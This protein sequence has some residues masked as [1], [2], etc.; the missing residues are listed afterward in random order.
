ML[1]VTLNFH[2]DA[3]AAK[4][5][6][7]LSPVTDDKHFIDQLNACPSASLKSL[8]FTEF[9][10]I[11]SVKVNQYAGH[12]PIDSDEYHTLFKVLNRLLYQ[13]QSVDILY[14]CKSQ[15]F[16]IEF[17]LLKPK[18]TRK[19]KVDLTIFTGMNETHVQETQ[20]EP[21]RPQLDSTSLIFGCTLGLMLA[22]I[23]ALN[24]WALLVSSLFAGISL[25]YA[26][27]EDIYQ[28]FCMA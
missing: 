11:Y 24:L 12:F 6:F 14:H 19:P 10:Q 25:C 22:S 16:K 1:L 20:T 21:Q 3:S 4:G 27:Q 26:H 8:E 7:F 15:A 9:T 28:R 5:D 13:N 2:A 17:Q 23:L 18:Q